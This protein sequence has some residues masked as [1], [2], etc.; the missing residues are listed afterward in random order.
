MAILS[1]EEARQILE[2][3]LGFAKADETIVSL[4]GG[5]GGNIRYARNTVS[6][7]GEQQNISLVVQSSYGKKSRHQHH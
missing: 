4:D 6:T 1:K 7:A 2:K 3:V 5:N